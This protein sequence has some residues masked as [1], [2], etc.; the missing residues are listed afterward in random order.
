M[1]KDITI[2]AVDTYAHELARFA[3]ERTCRALPCKEVLVLSDKNIYPD[4]RW[5]EINPLNIEEYNK[6]MIK[7]LWPFIRTE[8]ILVVQYDGMAVNSELW[9]DEFLQYDYIGAVWPWPHHKPGFKVGNGG[10][11]LRS[12]KLL[13]LL[14]DKRVVEDVKYPMYEDLYI[15]VHYKEH[16]LKQGAVIA[17][18]EIA[19]QF[20]HEHYP[21]KHDTFGFHGSFNVPYY[22]NEEDAVKFIELIPAWTSEATAMMIPHCFAAGK[23]ELGKLALALARKTTPDIDARIKAVLK[24]VPEL[25][26]SVNQHLGA[27]LK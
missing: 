8:H 18:E 17:S 25:G 3:I 7:H 14:K 23:P 26:L 15:G 2:V 4:G 1:T 24:S 9:S 13:H 27:M 11:S 20:S 5:V 19:K 22:L 16:L 6:I 10:F 21:G 12:R